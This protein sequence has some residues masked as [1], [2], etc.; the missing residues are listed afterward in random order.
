M[1]R[2]RSGSRRRDV[3]PKPEAKS[4]ENSH[5]AVRRK[6]S[7]TLEEFRLLLANA[8]K[9]R[10]SREGRY[11]HIKIRDQDHWEVAWAVFEVET[12]LAAV[13]KV[14]ALDGQPEA[15]MDDLWRV[16]GFARGHSDYSMKFALYCAEL[17]IHGKVIGP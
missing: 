9:E 14:R 10:K 15:N 7:S 1:T 5:L 6:W 4:S 8:Q 12:M 17:A 3:Q 16:E 11:V 13:N 2:P